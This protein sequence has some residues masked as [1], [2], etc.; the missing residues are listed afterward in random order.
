[1]EDSNGLPTNERI[2]TPSCGEEQRRHVAEV[3]AERLSRHR[4][5]LMSIKQPGGLRHNEPKV[6][7]ILVKD[8]LIRGCECLHH[9]S[10]NSVVHSPAMSKLGILVLRKQLHAHV[11]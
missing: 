9:D 10:G 1:M 7:S 3:K 6:L 8:H 4:A 5:L 11:E 2:A